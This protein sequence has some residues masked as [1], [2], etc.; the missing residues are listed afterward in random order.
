[1]DEAKFVTS[2]NIVCS[3]DLFWCFKLLFFWSLLIFFQNRF[4][5]FVKHRARVIFDSLT[6]S[7]RGPFFL[8]MCFKWSLNLASSWFGNVFYSVHHTNQPRSIVISTKKIWTTANKN[9]VKF[10]WK[11]CKNKIQRMV[12]TSVIFDLSLF[13]H[14]NVIRSETIILM[15]QTYR[16]VSVKIETMKLN[17]FFLGLL[18][19]NTNNSN[20]SWKANKLIWTGV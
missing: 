6:R 2:I 19:S 7:T 13:V 9:D 12:T 15:P 11:V 14:F 18:L 17:H 4:S 3:D 16:W 5:V 1:M 20:N 8:Q 10:G